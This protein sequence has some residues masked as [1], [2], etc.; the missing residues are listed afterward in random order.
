MLFDTLAIFG[1][2]LLGGSL[3]LA[4]KAKRVARHVIGVGRSESRLQEAKHAGILDDY[5]TDPIAG[6]TYADLVIV[7]TPVDDIVRQIR[8]IAPHCPRGCLITDV[9][10]TKRDIVENLRETASF[11]GS[12]PMAGSE[13]KGASFARADLFQNRVCIVTPHINSD[14]TSVRRI[15]QFWEALGSRVVE[16][17]PEQHDRAVAYIS[18]LPHAVAAALAGAVDPVHL[19]IAAGGFKDT[20]RIAAAEPTIWEPIFRTNREEVLAACDRFAEQFDTF[21]KLLAADDGAG[22]IRWLNEGKRVRDAVG[23]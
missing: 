13:K 18:H 12:H 10:S 16:M 7:C 14:R 6:V 4:A 22:L 17:S 11:V 5:T 15:A 9:G 20:T 2:G 21:R 19:A 3:G 1:V 8:E 23:S